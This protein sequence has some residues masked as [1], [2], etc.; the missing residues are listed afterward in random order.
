MGGTQGNCTRQLRLVIYYS[1]HRQAPRPGSQSRHCWKQVRGI[2]VTAQLWSVEEVRRQDRQAAQVNRDA[3]GRLR[4]RDSRPLARQ[5]RSTKATRE[6]P[7]MGAR[8]T[9]ASPR[10]REA[11]RQT[12][13]WQRPWGRRS[14]LC[15]LE[16]SATTVSDKIGPIKGA[17]PRN[18]VPSTRMRGRGEAGKEGKLMTGPGPAADPKEG[19]EARRGHVPG[20]GMCG[21]IGASRKPDGSREGGTLPHGCPAPYIGL[22]AAPPSEVLVICP[23]LR[24]EASDQMPLS[25]RSRRDRAATSVARPG[26]PERGRQEIARSRAFQAAERR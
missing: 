4:W 26:C 24:A 8:R 20:Q 22:P 1:S 12:A 2:R 9:A 13:P 11:S 14:C 19:R 7:D 18:S 16:R 25:H 21:R 23:G 17:W 6:R 5:N 15:Y 3:S 10:S